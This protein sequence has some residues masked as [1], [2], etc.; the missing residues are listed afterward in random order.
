MPRSL[1]GEW[2]YSSTHEPQTQMEI[3]D[4]LNAPATFTDRKELRVPT[5]N[6]TGWHHSE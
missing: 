6:K 4:Q 3:S 5:A 2:L 1:N